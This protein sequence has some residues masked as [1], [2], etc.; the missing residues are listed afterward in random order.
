MYLWHDGHVKREEDIRISPFDHGY[1]YGMGVFET[2]RTYGGHPF[3]FDDH[4]ERLQMSCA[5]IGI[6]LPY[7]RDELLAA[8]EE[9]YRIHE[10]SDVYIRL[11]VSAGER[12][13]GLSS[14]PYATPTVLM[15][16]KPVGP[17]RNSERALETIRLARSTPETSY[18]L[19]SHHYMNNLVAKRQLFNQEAEGLFLTKEGF[20]CE[21]IT[22]NIF[23]RYGDKWYTPPLETGALNGITRQF[24]MEQMPV[25]ERLALL[26]QLSEADEI[27]YTNSIQEAV[28]VSSLDGRAFPGLA[29][30]GYQ[31][32]Q[33]LF[34]QAVQTKWS[35]RE[36]E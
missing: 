29:G 9:L 14:E 15:Y 4:I 35:R 12:E 3:L 36:R 21:G 20:I 24:L 10:K 8:V 17:R 26:P 16:A 31:S 34:D 13:I 5:A 27:L 30:H 23:W 32:V 7:G 2:F 25:E 6:K 33:T 22:S 28:A 1:L 18:R 19:K 11:N